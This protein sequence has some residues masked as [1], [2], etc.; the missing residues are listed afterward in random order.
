LLRRR[1]RDAINTTTAPCLGFGFPLDVRDIYRYRCRYLGVPT[2]LDP[3]PDALCPILDGNSPGNLGGMNGLHG[4]DSGLDSGGMPALD[5]ELLHRVPSKL[6]E[7]FDSP[8][9]PSLRR[10]R[11]PEIVGVIDNGFLDFGVEPANDFGCLLQR[12]RG[13]LATLNGSGAGLQEIIDADTD[14]MNG[15]GAELGFLCT[16]RVHLT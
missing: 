11:L 7:N 13:T 1:L 3:G 16:H 6:I 8:R 4:E 12:M 5:G 14:F 10:R 15:S 2:I 9:D